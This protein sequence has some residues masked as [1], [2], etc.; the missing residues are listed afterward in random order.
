MILSVPFK[1]N[2][3]EYTNIAGELQINFNDSRNSFEKLIDFAE[4]YQ[5]HR[6]VI[7]FTNHVD[8]SIL[9]TLRKIHPHIY[10]KL[11]RA[12]LRECI[13]D[14][15]EAQVS[16]FVDEVVNDIILFQNLLALGVCAIYPGGDLIY[17]L[18]KIQQWVETRI[19]LN[20]VTNNDI[21]ANPEKSMFFSPQAFNVYKKYM[22]V[23]EF[24][25]GTP[26]NWDHFGVYYRA[27]FENQHWRGN[28]QEIIPELGTPIP[29]NSYNQSEF[30]TYKLLC[31]RKCG[32]D[33]NCKCHK[34]QRYLELAF[35]M[36]DRNIGVRAAGENI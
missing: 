2:N 35:V 26:Y 16:F 31:G 18:P 22:D 32:Y 24:D 30:I 21:E 34:C 12:Q 36:D 27:W 19:V 20:H 33:I 1:L 6:L 10:C 29:G 4:A 15:Y 23:V 11:T 25:C 5:N 7:T 17:R 9:R 13:T 3:D 8:V 28:L 14:L